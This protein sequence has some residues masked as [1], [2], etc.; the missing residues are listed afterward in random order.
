MHCAT[1]CNFI[2]RTKT[3]RV[4]HESVYEDAFSSTF[5]LII[6]CKKNTLI[7]LE[8]YF[9][10]Y[11]LRYIFAISLYLQMPKVLTIKCHELGKVLT[12]K[13]DMSFPKG[14]SV[15]MFSSALPILPRHSNLSTKYRELLCCFKPQVISCIYH[16]CVYN[17]G[18]S[19]C[20]TS[21]WLFRHIQWMT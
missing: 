4:R 9:S 17:Y 5:R 14:L 16:Y 3:E 13:L 10:V 11:F 8:C 15:L 18:C 19:C 6:S 1:G 12:T 2:I 20:K 7:W 21:L